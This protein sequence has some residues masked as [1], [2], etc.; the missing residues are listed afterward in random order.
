MSLRF[1][2]CQVCGIENKKVKS[3][4]DFGKNAKSKG[5]IYV[6]TFCPEHQPR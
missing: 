1:A 5:G 3:R 4:Y 2:R 6:G